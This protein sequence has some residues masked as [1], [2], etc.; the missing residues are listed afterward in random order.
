MPE[1]EVPAMST[2]LACAIVNDNKDA[3]A[4]AIAEPVGNKIY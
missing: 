3:Q 2:T 1:I 4:T